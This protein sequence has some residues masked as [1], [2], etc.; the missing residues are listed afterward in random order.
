MRDH[1]YELSKKSYVKFKKNITNS[2]N[3]TN[4]TNNNELYFCETLDTM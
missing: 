4:N 1:V 2:S 3:N